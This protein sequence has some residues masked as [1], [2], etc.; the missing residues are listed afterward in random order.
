MPRDPGRTLVGRHL[1]LDDLARSARAAQ[2]RIVAGPPGI[3]M[4]SVLHRVAEAVR[5]ER[6]VHELVATRA[7]ASLP[8]GVF[9]PVVDRVETTFEAAA[10]LRL[11]LVK[12]RPL[13]IVDDVHLLDRTSAVLLLEL[14]RGG[15]PLL[16]GLKDGCAADPAVSAIVQDLAGPPVRLEP[17]TE[18]ELARVIRAR[19]G[20]APD[21]GLVALVAG[22]S[23]GLP[24]YVR[25]IL[26]ELLAARRIRY[27]AGLAYVV[28][29]S[30]PSRAGGT[31]V[32]ADVSP[33]A[34][35]VA[36]LIALAAALPDSVMRGLATAAAVQEAEM[37]GL[38][39][40]GI[41]DGA[42]FFEPR[43]PWLARSLVADLPPSMR[44][45]LTRQLVDAHPHTPSDPLL[46]ARLLTWRT[47]LGP[48]PCARELLEG[49][50]RVQRLSTEVAAGLLQLA[51]DRAASP[52]DRLSVAAMLAH[53]HR[54]ADAE[55]LLAE[56]AREDLSDELQRRRDVLR[57]YV[58]LF[59][60]NDPQGAA[61]LLR[62][63]AGSDPLADA[64]LAT[65]S[66]QLG[67]IP[68]A[69]RV[70]RRVVDDESAPVAARAHAALTVSVAL[71]HRGRMAE[72]DGLRRLRT[73]LVV[74]A[75]DELPEG[76]EAARLFDE[77]ALLDVREALDAAQSLARA[78]YE[79]SLAH[80]DEGMRAQH[81]HQLA[82]IA[83][84]RG[85]PTTALPY[86]LGAAV[87][88]GTW[89]LALRACTTATLIQALVLSG[90]REEGEE[91]SRRALARPRA[92]L[93]DV[94]VARATAV[95]EAAL[96]DPAGA[97]DRLASAGARAVSRGQL[98]RGRCALDQAVRY[99]S[100]AAARA[101]LRLREE[102]GASA[103]GR[104]Q[105]MARGWLARDPGAL[106]ACA[107]DLTGRGLLWRAMEVAA[108]AARL[109][110]GAEPT[111]LLDLRLRCPALRSPVVAEAP[112]T[113]LTA[114]EAD[115]ARKAAAGMSD[116]KIAADAGL[117]IRTVQTHLSNAYHKLGIR[118]RAELPARL[119]QS[120]DLRIRT[121][122]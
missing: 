29:C 19:L 67:D 45:D 47:E 59:P 92:P 18:E 50:R 17:L 16:L 34:M 85:S 74:E 52:D 64:H 73:R 40:A 107:E 103:A 49:A 116:A 31:V 61:A 114:R 25:E 72:Y 22:W 11:A 15:V 84:E 122:T 48:A 69:L 46:A 81:S 2:S 8:L 112:P 28:G 32:G 93:Y 33:A 37:A 55:V 89:G 13:I 95:L 39:S 115:L 98:T 43:H 21:P 26:D 71:V 104:A 105:A 62:P 35:R 36:R 90:R 77:I 54:A 1:E 75:G 27:E 56:L 5:S 111:I 6:A 24:L 108:A 113:V 101:L 20:A 121:G 38:I 4:S 53:E 14:A 10:R 100:D 66:L 86:A 30:P 91:H 82:R 87:A 110:G 96:G 76:V 23:G 51:V 83:L 119:E 58:L 106:E 118:S 120:G 65:A 109:R 88:E 70:G 44:L 97:G 79:R 78:S 102:T 57:G 3:G 63:H 80:Q 117:S 7:S 68:A 41:R 9:L 60:R 99:G 42:L 94:E 12:S